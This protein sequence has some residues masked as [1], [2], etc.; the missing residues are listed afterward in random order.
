MSYSLALNESGDLQLSGN[1]LTIVVGVDKLIQDASV[2][3]KENFRIDRFHP[4]YGSLLD[5]YVG[6]IMDDSAEMEIKSE[7]LRVLGNYQALQS[8]AFKKDPALFSADELLS[9]VKDVRVVT[10]YDRLYVDVELETVSGRSVGIDLE[11]N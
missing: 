6:R 4:N 9:E 1:S 10:S 7:V 2:W 8:R 5:S 3:L 11:L